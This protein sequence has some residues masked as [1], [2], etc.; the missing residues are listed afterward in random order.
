MNNEY[1]YVK[2]GPIDVIIIIIERQR[3]YRNDEIKKNIDRCSKPKQ[4]LL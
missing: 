2:S 3:S 4:F 1:A